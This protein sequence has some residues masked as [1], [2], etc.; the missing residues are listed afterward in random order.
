MRGRLTGNFKEVSAAETWIYLFFYYDYFFY[1]IRRVSLD[2]NQHNF[3]TQ[4]FKTR[5]D[6]FG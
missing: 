1:T 3:Q 4:S 5:D 2:I 6:I